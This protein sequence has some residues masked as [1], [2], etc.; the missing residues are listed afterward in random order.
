MAGKQKKGVLRVQ[1]VSSIIV[2]LRA[3]G[4]TDKDIDDFLLWVATGEKLYISAIGRQE[5]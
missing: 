3:A 2:G 1:E 5:K 4:W